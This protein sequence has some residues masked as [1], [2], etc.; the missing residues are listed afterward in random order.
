MDNTEVVSEAVIEPKQRKKRRVM[1]ECDICHA[2]MDARG[3][4]GHLRKHG[5]G[6]I[7]HRRK[8]HEMPSN[9]VN[10]PTPTT[11]M[12]SYIEGYRKGIMDGMKMQRTA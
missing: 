6:R 12:D 3:I 8:K 10:F 1:R 7:M 11:S 2:K 5:I 4:N 9:Q